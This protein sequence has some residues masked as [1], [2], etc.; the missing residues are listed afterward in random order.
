MKRLRLVAIALAGVVIVGIAA[1]AVFAGLL[2]G[3][4]V[5]SYSSDGVT[6][7]DLEYEDALTRADDA[8]YTVE[9]VG[10]S[11]FHP[12]GLDELD[13]ELG[14]EYEAFRVTFDHSETKRLWATFHGEDETTVVTLFADDNRDD[15]TVDDLPPDAWLVDRLTLLFEMDEATAADYVEELKTEIR[16]SDPADPGA[17][18][19]SIE[20]DEPVAFRATYD[21]LTANATTVNA[22]S[23]PGT[24]WHE[25]EY[26]AADERLGSIEFVLSRATVTHEADEAIYRVHLDYHGGIRVDAQTRS[27]RNFAEEDVRAVFR[28]MFEEMGIPP[29][30]I[31]HMQ[32]EYEGSVW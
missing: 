6:V 7:S 31:D 18:T 1:Y 26:Y 23:T 25:R 8:G 29:D 12:D 22:S 20:I 16:T 32:L 11:G 5:A 10:S 13:A 9:R 19:P 15:F 24:G 2:I 4:D 17:S 30:T 3:S 27:S 21:S 14:P 28:Q